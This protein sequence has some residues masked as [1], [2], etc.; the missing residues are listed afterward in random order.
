MLSLHWT[1]L[2][3]TAL[4]SQCSWDILQPCWWQSSPTYSWIWHENQV[5]LISKLITVEGWWFSRLEGIEAD[6]N[7]MIAQQSVYKTAFTSMWNI[8]YLKAAFSFPFKRFKHF[9]SISNPQLTFRWDLHTKSAAFRL[10]NQ[11]FHEQMSLIGCKM[12]T[13]PR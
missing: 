11:Y 2:F 10:R 9:P 6:L 5:R 1:L 4:S 7:P 12:F 13:F 3:P 8:S